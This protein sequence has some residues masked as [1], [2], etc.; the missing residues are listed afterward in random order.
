MGIGFAYKFTLPVVMR[1]LSGFTI[2]EP[3]W[4]LAPTIN[5]VLSLLLAHA[6]CFEL[7]A[8]LFVLVHFGL[9]RAEHLASGRRYVVVGLFILAAIFTPPDVIS[10]LL[11]VCPLWILY[12]TINLYAKI[13]VSAKL[14]EH[15]G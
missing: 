11:L 1:F 12:E 5:F 8:L 2:G 13:R 10:Q 6:L 15:D 3:L 4:A 14:H 7:F 9:V